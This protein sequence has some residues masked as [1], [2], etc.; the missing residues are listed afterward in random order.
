M[1][2][3]IGVL[4]T[5]ST[6][7]VGTVTAYTCPT[8]KAAKVR[9]MFNAQGGAGATSTIEVFVNG[10]TIA[11]TAAI[12]ASNYVWSSK[13][14]GLRNAVSATKPDGTT[15]AQT[16]SPADQIYYLSAGQTIQYAVAG[17]ALTGMSFQV[18]GTEID[19]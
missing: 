15:A 12:A 13:G 16:V 11:K 5:V 18:V 14:A 7:T 2:D 1:S 3:K 17:E 10:A 4:G 9:L 8:A 6:T 19:V